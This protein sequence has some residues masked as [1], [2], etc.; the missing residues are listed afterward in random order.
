LK[1]LSP[2][3]VREKIQSRY[4]KK[5]GYS[6][7]KQFL[8][9]L[10]VPYPPPKGWRSL[11]ERGDP[12]PASWASKNTKWDG[13]HIVMIDTIYPEAVARWKK[14]CFPKAEQRLLRTLAKNNL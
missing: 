8:E 9:E 5:G 12:I 1:Q 3:E 6:F 2:K 7:T 11:L 4:T 14:T 10:G 13:T